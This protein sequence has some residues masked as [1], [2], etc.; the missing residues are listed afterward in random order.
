M[1]EKIVQLLFS[2][3][4]IYGSM[5]WL[6]RLGASEDSATLDKDKNRVLRL[7]GLSLGNAGIVLV[8]CRME[9][10]LPEQNSL[11]LLY[12]EGLLLSLLAGGLLAAACMDAR[13][14]YV[15]NYVWWWCLLWIAVLAWL[16]M[17]GIGR[18]SGNWPGGALAACRIQPSQMA[19]V[20]AFTAL[21]QIVFARMY[22]RADSHAFCVC[23]LASCLWKGELL[24]FLIHMLFSVMLL[25]IV[26]FGKRNITP[27]GRLRI[28]KPFVPYI[29]ITFWTQSLGMLYIQGR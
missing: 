5:L 11:L 13:S 4:V 8:L 19:A 18:E 2:G 28:P 1:I 3:G 15:Y 12:A 7:G 6:L 24:S 21:Q 23:A 25:A 17:G 20:L 27:E 10:N 9:Q 26:Q 16:P 14:C 29:I 22:G